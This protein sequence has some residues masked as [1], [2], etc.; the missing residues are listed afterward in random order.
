MILSHSFLSYQ[1]STTYFVPSYQAWMEQQDLSPA[2]RWHRRFLQQLQWR[3]PAERWLLKAPS[4]LPALEALLAVYPDAPV[5][6]THRDPLAVVASVAS[7]HTVLRSTFSDAV[8]ARAVGPEVAQ[9]LASDIARGLRA[10]DRALAADQ[11]LDV[12]YTDLTR[13]PLAVVHRIYAH[14]GLP[15]P[16]LAEA[17]MRRYLAEHPQHQHGV[18]EYSL[19]RFGLDLATEQ[20]R[21]RF[22][23]E[24]F[25]L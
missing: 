10:R 7:L 13:D 3:C 11:V 14:C 4:H 9:M 16:A 18:H 6:F 23:R 19:S 25:A 12:H 5:I 8:D 2:Y 17:R 20:E 1:F 15:L 22:Y 24:R 21:F